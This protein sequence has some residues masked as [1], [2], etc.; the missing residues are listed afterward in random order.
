[1]AW[2]LYPG[3]ILTVALADIPISALVSRS[4]PGVAAMFGIGWFFFLRPGVLNPGM[5]QRETARTKG[6]LRKIAA[7]GLPL[8]VAIVGASGNF[9][10]SLREKKRWWP[11]HLRI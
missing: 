11:R 9:N 7:E 6:H 10:K 2:P 1:M 5:L 3:I 4:W 8:I